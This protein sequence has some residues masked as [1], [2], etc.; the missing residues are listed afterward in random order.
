MELA[1]TSATAA[2][3]ERGKP[4][5]KSSIQLK[6]SRLKLYA[7]HTTLETQMENEYFFHRNIFSSFSEMFF[8]IAKFLK[9]SAFKETGLVRN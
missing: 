4:S 5:I 1:S 7:S 3:R 2:T 8:L 9:D 6:L